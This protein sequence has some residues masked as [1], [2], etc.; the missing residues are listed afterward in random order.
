MQS[1]ANKRIYDFSKKCTVLILDRSGDAL[2]PLVTPW[3]YAAMLHE[4]LPSRIVDNTVGVPDTS[5][6]VCS[7]SQHCCSRTCPV[8]SWPTRSEC[9]T[10]QK[11]KMDRDHHN[12]AP[13]APQ[14][15]GHDVRLVRLYSHRGARKW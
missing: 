6:K 15:I 7:C 1:T 9:R 10:C 5:G 13:W 4:Y 2:S 12:Q 8:A 3:T 11:E 14:G